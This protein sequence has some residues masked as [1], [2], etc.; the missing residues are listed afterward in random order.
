LKTGKVQAPPELLVLAGGYATRFGADKRVA[1]VS[2]QETLLGRTVAELRSTQLPVTVCL[3]ARESDDALAEALLSTGVRVLRCRRADEGMGGTLAEAV[4][5]RQE[6]PALIVAL[7]DMPLVS[8]ATVEALLRHW[9]A[10]AIVLPVSPD[11]RRGHPVLFDR[12]YFAE[13]RQ[14]GGDRGGASIISRHREH[15]VTVPVDDPGI[16]LDADTPAALEALRAQL[17]SRS[18]SGVSG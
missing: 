2:G 6:A 8:A 7:G 4:A 16:H 5:A 9:S 14:L 11:G 12:L 1:R 13:L 18:S 17:A 10:G 3:A 15:C